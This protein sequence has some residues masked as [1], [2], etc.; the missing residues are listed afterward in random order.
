MSGTFT[1]MIGAISVRVNN[2]VD[3]PYNVWEGHL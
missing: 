2:V 3:I 1:M